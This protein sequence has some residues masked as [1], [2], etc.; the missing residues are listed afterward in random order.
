MLAVV[1][2]VGITFKEAVLIPYGI[3]GLWIICVVGIGRRQW[4]SVALLLG[5]AIVGLFAITAWT[6]SSVGG[7]AS[8]I[9][10]V[11]GTPVSLATPYALECCW[12]PPNLLLQSFWI[13]SPVAALMSLVGLYAL[14]AASAPQSVSAANQPVIRLIALFGA[15]QIVLAMTMKGW[16]N[17]RYLAGTFPSFYLLAGFGF[18]FL[19]V[20]VQNRI[21]SRDYALTA[22]V[23]VAILIASAVGD[24]TRF[25]RVFVRGGLPDLSVRMI[26]D[27]RQQ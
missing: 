15:S 8:L 20:T 1:G 24:Y 26:I 3:C 22:V 6:A 21:K 12:G 7:W 23:A 19:A 2:S 9:Q 4:R 25:Q 11:T 16:L 10:I 14:Y 17:L 5:S 18:W 13:V 27:S